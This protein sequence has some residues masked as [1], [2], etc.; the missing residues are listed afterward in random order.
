MEAID[1]GRARVPADPGTERGRKALME[2]AERGIRGWA[3]RPGECE[4]QEG[5]AKG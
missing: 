5:E 4:H 3:A 1:L 2:V